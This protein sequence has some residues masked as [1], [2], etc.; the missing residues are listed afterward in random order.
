MA[1]T[2]SFTLYSKHVCRRSQML[3]VQE[4]MQSDLLGYDGPDARILWTEEEETSLRPVML[5]LCL[6]L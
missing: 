3:F 2:V 6:I 1:V 5:F 4:N